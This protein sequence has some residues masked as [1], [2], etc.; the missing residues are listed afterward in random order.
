MKMTKRI[1]SLLLCALM[2]LTLA[3]VS[4]FAVVENTVI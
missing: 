4:A 1:I 3:P 2:V